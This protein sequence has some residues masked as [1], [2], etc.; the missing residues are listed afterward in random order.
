MA[1]K[2]T[3]AFDQKIALN[4]ITDL[5]NAGMWEDTMYDIATSTDI[6][7]ITTEVLATNNALNEDD[8]N[9]QVQNALE[10][11]EAKAKTVREEN[12]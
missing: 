5:I 11:I 9:D 2:Y 7:Y 12:L 10:I 6:E 8:F 3:W 1:Y 4:A